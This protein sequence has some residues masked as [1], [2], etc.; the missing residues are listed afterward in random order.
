MKILSPEQIRALD[1][2][3]IQREPISSI[4]LMER[5]ANACYHWLN[6]HFDL[7]IDST[8]VI[9]CGSGNNGGDGWALGRILLANHPD[10]DI[11]MVD[12]QIGKR[13]TDN[14]ANYERFRQAYPAKITITTSGDHFPQLPT[15]SILIDALLGSGLNRPISGK[16][17]ALVTTLNKLPL[18]KIALDIPSGLYAQQHTPGAAILQT[19]HVLSFQLP[20]LAFFAPQNLPYLGQYHLLDIGLDQD[21]IDTSPTPY[22]CISANYLR[23]NIYQRQTF[24]HKGT[25][26]HCLVIAGSHGKLGA[27]ILAGRAALRAGAGLVTLHLPKC[28]YEVAQIAF[29][30][31]MC[32]VDQHR[33]IITQSPDLGAYRAIA[34][35]PGMG[36][37]ELTARALRQIIEQSTRPLVIDADALNLLSHHPEWLKMLP[38]GSMLTPHPKEFSRLFGVTSNDFSRWELQRDKAQELQLVILLKTAFTSIATPDGKLYFN[39]TGNP[40][41]GTA[42][43]GDV[44]TG[45]LA[46]LLAQNY[47]PVFAA[48]LGVYLHGLAGD[49]ATESNQQESLIASDVIAN[50]GAAFKALRSEA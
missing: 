43:T 46:G 39:T 27:A 20:K 23:E 4:A 25:F 47:P 12:C 9:C 50:I 31:A 48:Q 42:G 18:T 13:S 30:E 40:G 1:Q 2:A 3:T 21:F 41:M 29:P 22:S 10:L 37:D 19:Q 5:A 6:S 33:Y 38:P 24:D 16:W 34:I 32:L 45:M 35:G 11:R 14:A 49:L 26:G 28:G 44:L 36:T 15:K 17:A 7:S 8:W